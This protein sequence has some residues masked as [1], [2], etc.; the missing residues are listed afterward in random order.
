MNNIYSI[1]DTHGQLQTCTYW[2]NK[3]N[4]TP[5]LRE[6]RHDSLNPKLIE[7]VT[8]HHQVVQSSESGQ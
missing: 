4:L 2:D 6:S 8:L 5:T 1:L 7:V 3:E